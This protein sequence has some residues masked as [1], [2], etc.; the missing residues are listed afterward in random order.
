[1]GHQSWGHQNVLI[2]NS[3]EQPTADLTEPRILQR[4]LTFALREPAFG[5]L[6]QRVLSSNTQHGTEISCPTTLTKTFFFPISSCHLQPQRSWR[7]TSQRRKSVCSSRHALSPLSK[8]LRTKPGLC[9]EERRRW[10]T[11]LRLF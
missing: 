6:P 10:A 2:A 1:M 3:K 7:H 4:T 8:S 11:V 9:K 5:H